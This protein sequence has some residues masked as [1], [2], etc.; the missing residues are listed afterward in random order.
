MGVVGRRQ[1]KKPH[2]NSSA[3]SRKQRKY[4]EPKHTP[5]SSY[6]ILNIK[7]HSQEKSSSLLQKKNGKEGGDMWEWGVKS[8]YPVTA[9][10]PPLT[11]SGSD[12]TACHSTFSSI[13]EVNIS[14]VDKHDIT[15]LKHHG[16][17]NVFPSRAT[18][19]LRCFPVHSIYC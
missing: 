2:L 5:N 1:H 14:E 15:W 11:E 8:S 17:H 7:T 19:W 4:E 12:I 13:I 16:V 18:C 9:L 6:F 10:C 3:R